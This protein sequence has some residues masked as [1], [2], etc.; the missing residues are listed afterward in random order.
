M[1]SPILISIIEGFKRDRDTANRNYDAC[2]KFCRTVDF[3]LTFPWTDPNIEH[4]PQELRPYVSFF[5]GIP[6]FR[7]P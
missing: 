7:L 2:S 6:L 1:S 3:S 5:P 4:F